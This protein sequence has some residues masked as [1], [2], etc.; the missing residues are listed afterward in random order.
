MLEKNIK[1]WEIEVFYKEFWEK[2]RETILILHG[3]W[4]KSDSWI[5]FS[6]ILEKNNFRVIIPDLPWFGKTKLKRIFDLNDYAN[7]IQSFCLE[8]NLKDFILW[9]HSNGWAISIKLANKNSLKIERLVLNN[10]AWIRNDKKRSFKRKVLWFLKKILWKTSIKNPPAFGI[11][12]IKGDKWKIW[13]FREKLRILFYK[14]IWWQ[15]YLN[16]EK[17]PSLK[18]TYLNMI[19]S[20]LQEEIKKIELDTLLIWWEKD[21]YTPLF[22]GNLMRSFIKNSKIKVLFWQKHWIHIHN[23]ELLAKTF[24]DEI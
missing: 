12:L 22:D 19:S 14:L 1:V 5:N 10:S 20:D 3:W 15:D 13:G 16:A 8:L 6:E 7:L 17:D 4:G 9:G 23:P 24:L 2:N 11:P 21:T 18:W